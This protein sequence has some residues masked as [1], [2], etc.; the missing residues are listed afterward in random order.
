MTPPPRAS[1][2]NSLPTDVLIEYDAVG[3][4]ELIK[5]HE[6]SPAELVET[7]I[8]NI[9]RLN[10]PLNAV[11][12]PMFERALDDARNL[13]DLGAPFAGVPMLVKDLLARVANTRLT[14]GSRSLGS[15]VC[16]DD[17]E[18]V[19]RFRKAGLIIAG[20]TNTSEFGATPVTE[21]QLLGPA[22]NPWNLERT[23]GGSSGGSAAAV[24]TGMVAVAHGN[25]GG[26]SLR[27]PASCCGVFGFK[28]SRGRNPLGP[29]YGDLH[30]RVI[31]EH[32]IS[33]SVRD[34]A[35][36]LDTTH[37]ALPGSPYTP[38][39]PTKSFLQVLDEKPRPL[40]IAVSEKPIV[41]VPVH[42]DCVNGLQN[43]VGLCR[44]LGHEVIEDAPDL[45]ASELVKAW[46][47]VW[48]TGNAWL[49][50]Q[51]CARTGEDVS[52]ENFEPLTWRY[53]LQGEDTS[54]MEYLRNLQ[55][56]DTATQVLAG[57]LSQYDAWLTPTLAQP[58]IEL[59]G[60][61]GPDNDIERYVR[62]SPYCRLANFAGIPA[63]S[64][65]LHWNAQ[66]LP[67]GM[68]FA[69]PFGNEAILFALARQL[70]DACPWSDRRP[71]MAKTHSD[72]DK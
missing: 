50:H 22:R 24:A 31:C 32:V 23:T 20:K 10:E 67:I 49:V 44:S 57:F 4:A 16:R 6:I 70:E 30:T 55:V 37:G 36:V 17:S 13:S 52:E 15:Y 43:T 51:A 26:G 56:L 38:P 72:G 54:A 33:R 53:Y 58:P 8:A 65:P 19:K 41:D 59:G 39:S 47:G 21:S 7:A 29:E 35:A 68:H 46:F 61:Y 69:A 63:M 42:G 12:T 2:A 62:F 60:F 64:V 9:E 66:D 5:N 18:L 14:E 25:D 45:S 1:S 71:P 27:I 28:P 40:R 48:A 11:V 34:S 3:Q